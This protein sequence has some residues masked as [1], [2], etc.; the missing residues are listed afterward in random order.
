MRDNLRILLPIA[1]SRVTAIG[2]HG[3]GTGTLALEPVGRQANAGIFARL[4]RRLTGESESGLEYF[5]L[6]AGA[7]PETGGLDVGAPVDTDVYAPVDGT[8]IAMTDY[9]VNGIRYGVRIDLQ[10]SGNPGVVVSVD[11]LRPDP[12]LTV[13][14]AV[15]AARTKIGRVVDLSRV[16]RAALARHTQDQGHHVHVDVRPAASLAP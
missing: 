2:Y 14:S 10:P 3:A 12:A 7:G 15:S 16:E 6:E 8:V 4:V 1:Q 5:L 9:L 11:H 13:G